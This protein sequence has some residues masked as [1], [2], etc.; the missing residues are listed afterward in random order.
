[1]KNVFKAMILILLCI[2]SIITQA[3]L[4]GTEAITDALASGEAVYKLWYFWLG[5]VM[6]VWEVVARAVPTIRNWA[7]TG[8]LSSVLDGIIKNR[9]TGGGNFKNKKDR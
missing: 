9:V 3:Q 6:V 7:F 4:P 8:L 5:I 2:T 1:M